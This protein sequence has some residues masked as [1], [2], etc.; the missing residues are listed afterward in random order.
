MGYKAR[1]NGVLSLV[2]MKGNEIL[3]YEP[4]DKICQQFH[5]GPCLEIKVNSNDLDCPTIG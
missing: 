3:A 2:Y 5:D 4:W 1:V